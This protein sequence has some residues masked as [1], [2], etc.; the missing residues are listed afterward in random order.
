ML[1]PVLAQPVSSDGV[2]RSRCRVLEHSKGKKN[3]HEAG[4]HAAGTELG[5][6]RML[7][8]QSRGAGE[9]RPGR[10]R[11]AQDYS[12][13]RPALML[14]PPPP[15]RQ[16]C[17]PK[18]ATEQPEGPPPPTP[19]RPDCRGCASHAPLQERVARTHTPRRATPG[20]SL[21]VSQW[22]G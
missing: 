9:G 10:R 19:G 13:I 17:V 15:P 3:P 7:E 6:V 11:G 5:G 12:L 16:S 18:G 1:R 21:P 8:S 14:C 20:A 4:A 22:A 2:F